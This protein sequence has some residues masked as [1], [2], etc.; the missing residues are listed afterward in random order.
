MEFG[1][2]FK[3][4]PK[5]DRVVIEYKYRTLKSIRHGHAIK[6]REKI[7]KQKSYKIAYV[8]FPAILLA[9]KDG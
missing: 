4:K 5:K 7:L 8:K 2:E 6:M 1:V 3:S 9:W